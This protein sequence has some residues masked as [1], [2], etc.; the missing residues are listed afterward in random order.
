MIKANAKFPMKSMASGNHC[1]KS[2]PSS[3]AF[4]RGGRRRNS[5]LLPVIC[6]HISPCS[7]EENFIS[8]HTSC[9]VYHF[10]IIRKPAFNMSALD[11]VL[12]VLEELYFCFN[13]LFY[14]VFA[15]ACGVQLYFNGHTSTLILCFAG[16]NLAVTIISAPTAFAQYGKNVAI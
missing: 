8:M 9:S 13:F 14:L 7:E 2:Q 6:S 10:L 12:P 16:F 11:E 4:F 5:L 15:R 1:Q 3:P